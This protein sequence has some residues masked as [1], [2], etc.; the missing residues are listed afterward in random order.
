MKKRDGIANKNV[1]AYRLKILQ[2]INRLFRWIIPD[3]QLGERC[4]DQ[5]KIQSK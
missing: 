3:A 1:V 2:A 5:N 4:I